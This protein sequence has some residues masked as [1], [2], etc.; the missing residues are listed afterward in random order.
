MIYVI[1][2][3]TASG[4]STLAHSLSNKLECDIINI[5]AFQIYKDMDI[6]TNK[7]KIDDPNFSKYKLL[8]LITPDKSFSVKEYQDEFRQILSNFDYKNKN[9]IV[10]GGT[11][12]YIKASLFDYVFIEEAKCEKDFSSFNNEELY[13]MLK[14]V[15]PKATETIHM[16]NRKRVIR[17]LEIFETTKQSKSDQIDKQEHKLFYDE[18]YVKFIFL[19]PDRETLYDSINQRVEEMFSQ[20][21]L[22]EVKS[23]LE[24]YDLSETSKQAIGYKETISY[25]NNEI[26]FEECK[27][28]IK[29][30]TRNYAKRQV[31]FF[32]NQFKSQVFLTIDDAI[33]ELKCKE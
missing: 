10:V 3:P 14:E 27:E 29:K 24:K 20:G 23:L 30:R 9:I 13:Q 15:D 28:L 18:E 11:G 22:D 19:N 25:L 2:G 4:K 5:D 8:N 26:S 21:L 17:A 7:V 1:F 6:G 16:N 32:K 33:E 12:L 31:T